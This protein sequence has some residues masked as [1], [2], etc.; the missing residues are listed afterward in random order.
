MVAPRGTPNEI[1]AKLADALGEALDD[2]SVQ[3]RYIELGSSAPKGVD[4]GP[5]GLQRLV[6]SEIARITPIIEAAGV[7]AN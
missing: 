4:R 2:P 3:A 5:T 6:E 7:T 1:V